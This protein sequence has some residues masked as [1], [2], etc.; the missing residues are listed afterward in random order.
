MKKQPELDK[1]S[2]AQLLELLRTILAENEKL[3]QRNDQLQETNQQLRDEIKRLKQGSAAA[4]VAK[5]AHKS[6][7][8]AP[9]RKSA[10]GRFSYRKAPAASL[11]APPVIDGVVSSRQCPRC[12]SGLQTWA[13]EVITLSDLPVQPRPLLIRYQVETC[14]C[15]SCGKQVRA[16]H[17]Q[18]PASQR[19]ATAHRLGSRA[20]AAAHLLHYQ[21][22]IPVRKLPAVL[23]ELTGLQV[24]QSAL[25]QAALR[26]GCGPGA[27]AQQYAKLRAAVKEQA[28]IYTDD[29]GWPE[30]GKRAYLM[31]FDSPQMT[32]Y[33]IRERHRNEE[34]RELIGDAYGGVL[35]S[36]RGKSYDAKELIAVKQQK[37]LA[38]I[39]RSIS[40]VLDSSQGRE[41]DFGLALKSQLKEAQEVKRQ[42]AAGQLTG[43]AAARAGNDLDREINLH[44]RQR[45]LADGKSERLRHQLLEHHER[46][47]LLRFLQEREVEATNN[48]AE[49]ALRP[50]VIARKVSQ[51]TKNARGSRAFE[52][53]TSVLRT[54]MKQGAESALEN[55]RQM[56]DRSPP[57]SVE[58][59]LP[60]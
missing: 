22:G 3:Q 49:R 13:Q 14:R 18:I 6:H 30:G 27:V 7:A 48:A 25:T 60:G 1:L 4:P 26:S 41:R 10:H 31:A 56:L 24:T 11:C 29:T 5:K 55:L 23:K 53:F 34:V 58:A 15:P 12:G 46:G 8:K 38:H 17:P 50:A 16:Q 42:R 33:Q 57:P 21:L 35:T 39:Q 45:G 59:N 36:D 47:N 37:C 51:G 52:A 19:G 32:V 2:P 40:E 28:I 9:G 44:L 54:Q 43:K 20:L